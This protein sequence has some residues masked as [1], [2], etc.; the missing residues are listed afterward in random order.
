M[1]VLVGCI[2]ALMAAPIALGAQEACGGA[3][4][5]PAAGGWGEFVV[6]APGSAAPT[7]V[8]YAIVGAEEVG[9]RPLVR[10]ETRVRGAGEGEGIVTQVLVPGY[11]Y[12]QRA[13]QE[14]VVQRGTGVPARWSP[15]LLNRARRSPRSAL[16]RLIM[17]GCAGAMLV[18]EEQVTVPAGAFRTRHYRNAEVGSDIWVSDE[19]PFGLVKVTG[20]DGA[21]LE[22][23]A[24]GTDARSSVTG[25]ARMVDGPN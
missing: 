12:E 10:F 4:T 8:R 21:T 24:R 7:T 15:A 3:V 2:G 20:R 11:P 22:L 19:V 9:G 13:L 6:Q 16:A 17:D 23:L 25:E 1:R 14:V 5:A 18:G